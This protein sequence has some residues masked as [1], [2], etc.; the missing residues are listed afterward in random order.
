MLDIANFSIDSGS[1]AGMTSIELMT[2][3]EL[4]KSPVN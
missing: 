3:I 2:I 4:M 1:G